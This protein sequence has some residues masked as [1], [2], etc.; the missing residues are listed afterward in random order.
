LHDYCYR[1]CKLKSQLGNVLNALYNSKSSG[2]ID[3]LSTQISDLRELTIAKLSLIDKLT[4][5]LETILRQY[6]NVTVQLCESLFPISS[7]GEK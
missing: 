2:E 5:S 7:E 6:K 3:E 4:Q 1:S